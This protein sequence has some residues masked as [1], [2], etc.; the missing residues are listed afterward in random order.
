MK[1]EEEKTDNTRAKDFPGYPHYPPSEDMF[2]KGV[3][4]TNLDP[5]NPLEI[6]E[7]KGEEGKAEEKD[8]EADMSGQDLDVPGSELDDQQESVG[9]ED[10]ENNHYS[11]GDDDRITPEEDNR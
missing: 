1:Q 3:K 9:S 2:I 7:S 8:F 4:V 11:L 10:E 6:N 5:E